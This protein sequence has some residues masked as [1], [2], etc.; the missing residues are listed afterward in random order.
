MLATGKCVDVDSPCVGPSAGGLIGAFVLEEHGGHTGMIVASAD[1]VTVGSMGAAPEKWKLVQLGSPDY[2]GWQNTQ[3]FCQQGICESLYA[4]LAP[5]GKGIRELARHLPAEYDSS[6]ACADGDDK[7]AVTW[8]VK[9]EVEAAKSDGVFP[10][11]LTVTG[12]D[13]GEQMAPKTYRVPF[14]KKSWSY[15]V[16]KEGVFGRE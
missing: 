12:E 14:D 7:C 4:I 6:G 16:P 13:K 5:Y 8:Q 9:L 3:G 15:E 10:L 1:K 2:W 11:L